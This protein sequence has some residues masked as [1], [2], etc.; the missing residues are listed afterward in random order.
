MSE[1]KESQVYLLTESD[2][3]FGCR[4]MPWESMD[5][6]VIKRM[7][8]EHFSVRSITY[9]EIASGKVAPR[10]CVIVHSSSQQP[11]YKQFVDDVLLYRSEE[12][13]SELQSR[14]H[15]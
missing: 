4:L 11:E 10:D 9:A 1:V 14:L 15:L 8:S 2:G 6:D 5:V 3:F 12:H 7:L 13:T